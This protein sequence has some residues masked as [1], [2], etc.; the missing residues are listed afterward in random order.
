MKRSNWLAAGAAAM[1]MLACSS[2]KDPAEQVI[3]KMD[4][5]LDAIHDNA[6]KYAPDTLKSVESQVSTLKQSLAKGDYSGVLTAAPPV[7][8]AIANLRKDVQQKAWDADAALAK[9]KQQWRTLTYEVPKLVAGLHTQVD[10]LSS[11][12]G[13]PR[14]VTK[15]SFASAKDGVAS[16]D[17]M[18]T[19]ANT[20]VSTGDYA[21][22]VTKGQAV[23]DKA[24]E[25]MHA[26]GMKPS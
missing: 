14:G 9:V 3:A 25:L 19:D 1:L 6:A 26:L 11:G 18:W 5:S 20:S 7:N 8:M 10:T 21:G 12:H 24:T 23:K 13:L 17:T 15:A 22:A 16:L 4:T 2:Q